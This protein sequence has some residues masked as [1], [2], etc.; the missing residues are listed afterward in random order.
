MYILTYKSITVNVKSNFGHNKGCQVLLCV[1]QWTSSLIS[2]RSR[3]HTAAA[4]QR[5]GETFK[6]FLRIT[7]CC[8][9]LRN[10]CLQ[11]K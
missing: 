7:Q 1:V 8:G 9:S 4:K 5:P 11:I 3:I 10:V 6:P 2:C